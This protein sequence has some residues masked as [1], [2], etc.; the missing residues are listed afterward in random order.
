V[1]P[2]NTEKRKRNSQIC[3]GQR[4]PRRLKRK[5][6]EGD[7][8]RRSIDDEDE[9]PK[10]KNNKKCRMSWMTMKKTDF[11]EEDKDLERQIKMLIQTK[12]L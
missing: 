6:F 3:E 1:E 9:F 11:D 7:E 10:S 5:H 4:F 8:L 2:V 12:Q